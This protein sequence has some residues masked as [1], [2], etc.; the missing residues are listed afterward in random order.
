[1]ELVELVELVVEDVPPTLSILMA[2]TLPESVATLAPEF[3]EQTELAKVRELQS[4]FAA[5]CDPQ[6]SRL[7]AELDRITVPITFY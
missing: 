7:V 1:M 5:H 2:A 3:C 6:S 4:L